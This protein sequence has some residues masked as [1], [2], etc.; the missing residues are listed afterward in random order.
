MAGA[1]HPAAAA[2]HSGTF[3]ELGHGTSAT[4]YRVRE[5]NHPAALKIFLDHATYEKEMKLVEKIFNYRPTCKHLIKFI[6]KREYIPRPNPNH[7]Q[8]FPQWM[9]GLVFEWAPYGTVASFIK[10]WHP[11]LTQNV[12]CHWTRHVADALDFL[13]S[14]NITIMDLKPDNILVRGDKTLAVADFGNA[15]D[16]A[17]PFDLTGINGTIVYSSLEALEKKG[18][19]HV[20]DVFSLGLCL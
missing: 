11:L 7:I 16:K 1:N 4:V 2:A 8:G 15:M 14:H 13:S 19:T 6:R 9:D 17:V 20:T 3:K 5:G 18:I 10:E 12:L